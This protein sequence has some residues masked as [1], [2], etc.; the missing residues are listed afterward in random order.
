MKKV[1]LALSFITSVLCAPAAERAVIFGE[2]FAALTDGSADMPAQTELSADGSVDVALTHGEQWKGRGLHAAGGSMAVLHFG[3]SQGYVQT[4][5]TDV[6]LDGGRFTLR[7]R[8]RT[9]SAETDRLHVELY[10]PYTTNSVDTGVAEIGSEWE[11]HELTLTHPGYGNHLAYM[12]I[13][14]EGNDWLLD[15]FEIVQDYTGLMPP[16]AH[17]ATGVTYSQFTANWNAVPLAAAYL[18]SAFSVDDTGNRNYIVENLRTEDCEYTVTG[19]ETGVDYYYTVASVNDTYTSAPCEPV[20][21]HVPLTSVDTPTLLPASDLTENGFTARWEPV[22]RAMGYLV[23]LERRHT[24]VAAEDFVILHEDFN[25]F[26]ASGPFYGNLDDYTNMP[27]WKTSDWPV[28]ANGKFGF[29]N[30]WMQFEGPGFMTSPVLDLS[31]SDGKFS[32]KLKV[33][34]SRGY[35]VTAECN[36]VVKSQKLTSSSQEIVFDFDNGTDATS[37]R[38]SYDGS[39]TML[40]DDIVISQPIAAGETVTQHIGT[41]NTV[42][43]STGRPNSP[44]PTSW[45]FTGLTVDE[46]DVFVYTVKAWS[47]SLGEDGVWGPTI[48]SALSSPMSVDF[49][50]DSGIEAVG[51]AGMEIWAEGSA[52]IVVAPEETS[53]EIYDMGGILRGSY[54]VAPGTTAIPAPARGVLVVRAGTSACRLL[55]R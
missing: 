29:D 4:P 37:V 40:F 18:V 23:Y 35:T 20:R 45:T 31:N 55:V 49:G 8:A 13:A 7:F 42:D 44:S 34:A 27:G 26:G 28:T 53:V 16:I 17:H 54:K 3:E 47:W 2:D 38:F 10:D 14:S 22:F 15:D 11:T 33:S 30:K 19:T 43:D 36:G 52:I 51:T 6:R 50:A 39:S 1:L 9:T 46:G 21:V 5:Y 32:I 25:K 41:Y 12:Q 48:Y 24:A